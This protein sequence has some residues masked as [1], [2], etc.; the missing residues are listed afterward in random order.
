MNEIA[1][2]A[3]IVA[4]AQAMERAGL[5]PNRS[6]NVSCRFDGGLLI[7]P[8]G[9]PYDDMTAA[10]IV[11]LDLAGQV[12]A[13]TRT[14]S[15]ESPFHTAIYRSRP[16]AEAIVHTHS[17]RATALACARRPIPPFHY[18]IALAGGPGVR[19]AEYAT[20]GT[21][22]LAENA[23]RGLEGRR[24]VLLANHGVIAIGA[25][26][27]AAYEV[28]FEVENMAGQYLQM[29]AAG[30]EPV[31]LDEAEM[32]RVLAQFARYGREY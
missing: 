8:S 4:T 13:G 12:R 22:A 11:S 26:L 21:Q 24:A 30:L 14:P 19:C 17:P 25:T 15:S 16:D 31:T 2:R 10:D 27:E 29:L 32:Q 9:I 23:L 28:A 7:T 18:M 6:G 1:A 20:F 3:A 5:A